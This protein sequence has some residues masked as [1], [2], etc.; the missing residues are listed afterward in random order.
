MLLSTSK[1]AT[2]EVWRAF[3]KI[4]KIEPEQSGSISRRNRHGFESAPPAIRRHVRTNVSETCLSLGF[5]F[6]DENLRQ[7]QQKEKNRLKKFL[8]S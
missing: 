1:V 4:D 7:Q 5:G 3:K 6:G 2:A 8:L